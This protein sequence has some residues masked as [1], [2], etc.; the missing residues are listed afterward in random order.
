ML[1]GCL[2]SR[3]CASWEHA[4]AWLMRSMPF[5]RHPYLCTSKC[6]L[7]SVIAGINSKCHMSGI[8]DDRQH[9]I[10]MDILVWTSVI[11]TRS[12]NP[13]T[14]TIKTYMWKYCYTFGI[15]RNVKST[16]KLWVWFL[17]NNILTHRCTITNRVKDYHTVVLF[18]IDICHA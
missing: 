5:S 9:N 18:N 8:S 10:F 14:S 11:K 3:I 1:E 17:K 13:Y 16:G 15:L 12:S 7:T 4:F 6:H 2:G